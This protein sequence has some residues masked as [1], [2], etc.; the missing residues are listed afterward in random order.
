MTDGFQAHKENKKGIIE[1]RKEVIERGQM[2]NC[3]LRWMVKGERD[4]NKGERDTN[5]LLDT[6]VRSSGCW[7]I[8]PVCESTLGVGGIEDPDDGE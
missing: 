5:T 1:K 4:T 7:R 6:D 2:K 8:A 3:F